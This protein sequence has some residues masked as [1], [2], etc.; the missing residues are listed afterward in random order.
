MA[1]I[2]ETKIIAPKIGEGIFL[3]G[4][5]SE[6]L[7]LPYS[8]V[9]NWMND[10]W[11]SHLLGD[12]TSKA[13]NFYTLIEFQIFYNLRLRNISAQKIKKAHSLI[14]KDLGTK[15]PFAHVKITTQSDQIWY[16]YL[17]FLIKAD[18][19]KQPAIKSFVEPFMNKIEFGAN[20]IATKLF[21][22]ENSKNIVVDPL[23]QFGQPTINGRNI[24]AEIIK[25][26]FEGGESKKNI[27][28]LYD[29]GVHQ[30]DD[31]LSYYKI[32]A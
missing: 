9:R 11:A 17:D 24:R 1:T 10:F 22:L 18:G 5:V 7:G 29:L 12:P 8:R 19:R 28:I 25:K 15:Y 23:H 6:I 20:N 3:A 13:V 16:E 21:P 26:M 32:S 27:C 4:D 14:A 31:A 2:S 30:V